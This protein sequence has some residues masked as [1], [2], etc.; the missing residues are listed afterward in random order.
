MYAFTSSMPEKDKNDVVIGDKVTKKAKGVNSGLVKKFLTF[1]D[2][3]DTLFNKTI[4]MVCQNSIRS[5]K[6]Q[7]YT[8]S[9]MKIAT[10]AIDTKRYTLPNGVS[11]Y[12][13]GHK[14][15]KKVKWTK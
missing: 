13:H 9:Q 3:K 8:I 10:T 12:A 2:Y 14:N 11:S 7:L 1:D 6:H 15:I 4:T 5:Y